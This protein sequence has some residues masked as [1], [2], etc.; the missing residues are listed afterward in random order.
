[1]TIDKENPSVLATEGLFRPSFIVQPKIGSALH[2]SE[3]H[4][5]GSEKSEFIFI[6]RDQHVFGLTVMSEHHF[7]CFSSES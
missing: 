2:A 3:L 1:M 6:V 5:K 4:D 7:M